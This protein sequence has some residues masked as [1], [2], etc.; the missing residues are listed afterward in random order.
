MLANDVCV[1][2]FH[3]LWC[4]CESIFWLI[5]ILLLAYSRAGYGGYDP[6]PIDLQAAATEMVKAVPFNRT[7]DPSLR[8]EN[9]LS[10]LY[11]YTLFDPASSGVQ[12]G[13]VQQVAASTLDFYRLPA[14]A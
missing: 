3:G 5:F 13:S 7:R 2:P 11:A 12:P 8:S 14:L 4:P 9:I 10:G 6:I 1:E